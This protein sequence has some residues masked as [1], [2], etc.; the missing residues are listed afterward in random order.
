MPT[1]RDEFQ[2]L[3][4]PMWLDYTHQR[5]LS[6]EEIRYRLQQQD[7][8]PPNWNDLSLQIVA[9]RK[10]GSVPLFLNCIEKKFWFFPSDSLNR[11][12]AEIDRLGL[13]L[14]NRINQQAMFKEDFFLDSTVEE[15]ITSAI[16]EGAHS[17][18]AQAQQ[19][20]ASG[21]KPKS[22][23]EWMLVNN[24]RAMTWVQKHRKDPVTLDL[25]L[26]LHRIVTENTMEGD[27][28]NFPGK[29]RNDKVFVGPHEGIPHQ[30]IEHAIAETIDLTTKCPRYLHP[31]VRG[32]LFHYF[33]AYIHPFFDGNGRTARALFYFKAMRNQLDYVQLLS[34]SAYLKEHGRQYEKAFEKVVSNELDVTYFID[35]CLD[36]IHSALTAVSTK[37]SYLLRINALRDAV[38]LTPNQVGLLQRMAL[39]KFRT[40]SIE[41]YARQI[42]MS[43]EIARQELKAL[44]ERGLVQESKQGKKLVYTINKAGLEKLIERG[45]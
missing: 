42:N 40:V 44:K 38:G 25:V 3:N 15:A 11:K 28:A 39:H 24:Y 2:F 30:K 45:H 21:N 31:L 4:S 18:R 5:Y 20:I 1:L 37:V 27:D 19:L 43:R 6:P 26:S 35:F 33:I 7:K 13:D 17:T 8:L 36:S 41:D 9:T 34:V 22:K 29:F 10:A 16:Y 14:Y 32:I 12:V 23:D